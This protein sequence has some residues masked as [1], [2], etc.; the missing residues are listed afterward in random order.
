M[1]G[2]VPAQVLL[3][4]TGKVLSFNILQNEFYAACGVFDQTQSER[5]DVLRDNVGLITHLKYKPRSNVANNNID[6][7]YEQSNN[8]NSPVWP[9]R[10]AGTL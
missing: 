3:H 10:L 7:N 6:L 9:I 4:S 8:G 5:F 2:F 1:D